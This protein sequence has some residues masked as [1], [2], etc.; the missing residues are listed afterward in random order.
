MTD[1]ILED[2]LAPVLG[3]GFVGVVIAGFFLFPERFE[4]AFALVS[5]ALQFL[6]L[7]SRSAARRATKHVVQ[8]DV[9]GLLR[10][11]DS[12]I[13]WGPTRV[14]IDWLKAEN[15]SRAAVLASNRVIIRLR[16]SDPR[17]RNVV[18]A[19]AL[20]A[21]ESLLLRT[22]RYL[23]PDQ[24][25]ALSLFVT[26]KMFEAGR[27]DLL[28]HFVEDYLMP[29][30][31]PG[32]R[33]S[34]YFAAFESLH[35]AG[36]F[37]QMTLQELDHLGGKVL[38]QAAIPDLPDEVDAFI[39]FTTDVA[40]RQSR[41]EMQLTFSR[42]YVKTAVVI[43][44]RAEKMDDDGTRYVGYI[45]NVLVPAGVESV[46]VLSTSSHV[47]V[48]DRIAAQLDYVYW[49]GSARRDVARYGD[50]VE[51]DRYWVLLRSRTASVFHPRA[52]QQAARLA[53]QAKLDAGKALGTVINA[54]ERRFAWVDF[55][56]GPH[57]VYVRYDWFIE[58]IERLL[59]GDRVTAHLGRDRDGKL[60]VREL[61]LALP[62]A[63]E[64]RPL[65]PRETY[66]D[67]VRLR[68]QSD[69]AES[70]QT[71]TEPGGIATVSEAAVPQ[72]SPPAEVAASSGVEP[73]AETLDSVDGADVD[74]VA[75]TTP[76]PGFE[77]ATVTRSG[78]RP[79]A[80]VELDS[81]QG[82]LFLHYNQLSSDVP[83]LLAG[84]RVE[85]RLGTSATGKIE[86]REAFLV[87]AV[88]GTRAEVQASSW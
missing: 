69:P 76:T 61:Q 31:T 74:E 71:Q 45:E 6:P 41:E 48:V 35:R 22:R 36:Y 50:D 55:D 1:Q 66:P 7:A 60:R 4:K 49:K 52:A 42:N 8:A 27:P 32:G 77:L 21:S 3:L 83:R 67:P 63:G 24:N 58:P 65:T 75:P 37:F 87:A 70:E 5:R 54:G 56:A 17:S 62:V 14:K 38:G 72:D 16:S 29:A 79:F 12:L 15:A 44:G 84:D 78:N 64:R 80:F 73:A 26:G 85:V 20:F 9:R 82:A 28:D 33:V 53:P 68:P 18:H 23:A 57:G 59:I 25:K 51:F 39:D 47:A 30:T 19:T 46:Y 34:D 13:P 86:I 2:L 40:S 88:P 11:A 81:R 43:V 10:S